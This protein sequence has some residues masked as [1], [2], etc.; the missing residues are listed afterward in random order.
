MFKQ[1]KIYKVIIKTN[2]SCT[3]TNDYKMLIHRTIFV[4][5]ANQS[6]FFDC[7]YPSIENPKIWF[8]N[9]RIPFEYMGWYSVIQIQSNHCN[10]KVISWLLCHIHSHIFMKLSFLRYQVS[11][12]MLR[13][14]TFF[15]LGKVNKKLFSSKLN[16]STRVKPHRIN[17][18]R[19]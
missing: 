18:I 13:L 3:I 19:F 7:Q 15:Q 2:E 16:I 17:Q 5:V 1:L 9:K 11:F 14:E 6:E 8:W 4:L 10:R 12:I